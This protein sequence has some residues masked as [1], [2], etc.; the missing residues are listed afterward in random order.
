M[1]ELGDEC[2]AVMLPCFHSTHLLKVSA[3]LHHV[4]TPSHTHSMHLITCSPEESNPAVWKCFMADEGKEQLCLQ[5]EERKRRTFSSDQTPCRSLAVFFPHTLFPTAALVCHIFPSH[6]VFLFKW[7][8]N[9]VKS[10]LRETFVGAGQSSTLT[11]R[12]LSPD[13]TSNESLLPVDL[14]SSHKVQVLWHMCPRFWTRLRRQLRD[15]IHRVA[16]KH[17]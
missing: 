12:I 5:G 11:P 10:H 17:S 6:N 13:W 3:W 9:I 2:M 4:N 8:V 14:F 16:R 1:T 15:L 7:E